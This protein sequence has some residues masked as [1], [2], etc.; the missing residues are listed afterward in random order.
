MVGV[1]PPN[2]MAAEYRGGGFGGVEVFGS[3]EGKA[4]VV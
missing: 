1:W 3:E 4:A 2:D